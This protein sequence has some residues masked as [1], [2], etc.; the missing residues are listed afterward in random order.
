[1]SEMDKVIQQNAANAEESASASEEM[2]GRAGEMREFV[3]ELSSLIGGGAKR[4][5]IESQH[6]DNGRKVTVLLPYHSQKNLT[7]QRDKRR[8]I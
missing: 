7:E 6:I 8:L 5:G 3:E 2:N 1:V 4:I